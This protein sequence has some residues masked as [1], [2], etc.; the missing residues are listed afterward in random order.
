VTVAE[1][2]RRQRNRRP[3]HPTQVVFAGFAGVAILGTALLLLPFAKAGPGAAAWN[4][5]LFTAVSAL[6]VT[7]LV[8]VDT[9]T[10]WTPFGEAVILA[11]IQVGGFGVMTFASFVGLVIA[12]RLSYRGRINAATEAHAMGLADVRQLIMN[13]VAISVL[14]ESIVAVVLAVHGMAAY[15]M[16]FGEAVWFGVFHGIS[17][18][19]NAGFALFSDSMI[20]FVGDP[21]V[22]LT[23]SC[24]IILGGLGFPVIMQLRRHVARPRLWTM[25]T[26]LV[27]LMTLAL[28]LVGT[29]LITALEW[30][31][32]D[33]LGALRW[34]QRILAGFFQSVQTRTAGFNSV[35]IG[36]MDDSTLLGMIVLMF[37][38]GGPAG[39][40][41]GIKITTFG[42]LLFILLAEVRG[43]GVVNVLGKRLSRAVH[44]QAIAV[45]LLSV[46][47]VVGATMLLQILTDNRLADVLFESVSA[48]ATVG[49]STGITASLPPSAQVVLVVLMF[50]GRLGPITFAT[51]LALRPRSV[52]YQFPKERPIIG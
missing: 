25:N 42:V 2:R 50:V 30:S 11:L 6:C 49:L 18:F 10:Y 46:A 1:R 19:N 52:A 29:V 23:L 4:E 9:P 12:R 3:L 22:N 20:Q 47:L 24:A 41:G 35:D 51:A 36:A 43:D 33:T 48:F 15:G 8:V 32:P 21:V 13:V 38:G 5:A 31:N 26:R 45:V 44:R 7:G 40:A 14:I 39:T 28:L 16:G 17:A 27:L 37:I 34:D